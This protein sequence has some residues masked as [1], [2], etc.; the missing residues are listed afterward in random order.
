MDYHGR[1]SKAP[2]VRT[3]HNHRRY[4]SLKRES[5]PAKA[6]GFGLSPFALAVIKTP[7]SRDY[8]NPS[9][10]RDGNA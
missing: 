2:L 5:M 4:Y 6:S 1:Y 10:G 3:Q 9:V 8:F 7:S